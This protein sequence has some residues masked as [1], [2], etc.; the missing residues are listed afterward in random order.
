M[1]LDCDW[2]GCDWSIDNENDHGS[3]FNHIKS[4]HVKTGVQ[5]CSW[6]LF[7]PNQEK[8]CHTNGRYKSEFLDH[9]VSHMHKSFRPHS[10]PICSK[11]YRSNQD[12]RRHK[13]LHSSNLNS[14]DASFNSDASVGG[15]PTRI[16]S[17]LTSFTPSLPILDLL[18]SSE[19]PI[20]G[21]HYSLFASDY[22]VIF[23]LLK[24]EFPSQ[25]PQRLD[26]YRQQDQFVPI[27]LTCEIFEWISSEIESSNISIETI[28]NARKQHLK[29]AYHDTISTIISDFK[30]VIEFTMNEIIQQGRSKVAIKTLF[31]DVP[32]GMWDQSEQ[33]ITSVDEIKNNYRDLIIP[34]F[35]KFMQ[36]F[37]ALNNEVVFQYCEA[38]NPSCSSILN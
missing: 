23:D 14:S 35:E 11:T 28:M 34:P 38:G 3:L 4:I 18:Q 13:R 16:P 10:C 22:A 6:K 15:T 30:T 26:Q 31:E 19:S 1:T 29:Q 2:K 24:K 33:L 21:R 12:L 8:I 27:Q 36:L 5:V 37:S 9:M 32:F 7:S 25:F 17:S 20:I